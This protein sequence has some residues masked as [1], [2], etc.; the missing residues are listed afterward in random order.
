[1][2][3]RKSKP[4]S[5]RAPI[6]VYLFEAWLKRL[7]AVFPPRGGFIEPLSE[8]WR[9]ARR[10]RLTASLR[11]E[12]IYKRNP[13]SWNLLMD[14]LDAEL[15]P[16]YQWTE[17]NNVRALNWGRE[18]EKEALANVELNYGR[19]I[20]DPGLLFH[21]QHP[22][23]AGTPDGLIRKA[24]GAISIQIKCPYD[25]KIHL[26]ALYTKAL[27]SLYYAQVQQEAW[28]SNA[29]AIEFYSY[30]PR[31]PLVTRLVRLDVPV[32]K[33]FIARLETNALDFAALFCAGTRLATGKVTPMGVVGG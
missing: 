24:N 19:D 3:R 13:K 33:E 21:S 22:F 2:A 23:I 29:N 28:V 11:A 8:D 4:E 27:S 26:A 31:Q 20:E 16:D 14:K 12:I 1:M 9:Q 7:N 25:S 32:N 6:Q 18:H 17:V 15:S 5:E 30:D 10:G